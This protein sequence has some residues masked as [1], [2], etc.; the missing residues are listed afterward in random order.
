MAFFPNFL[1]WRYCVIHDAMRTPIPQDH[2]ISCEEALSFFQKDKNAFIY[3]PHLFLNE[4]DQISNENG[5]TSDALYKISTSPEVRK[6]LSWINK[7][8]LYSVGIDY[9]ITV[10]VYVR[11]GS[12][13]LNKLVEDGILTKD[14]SIA[15]HDNLIRNLKDLIST[16][17]E[18]SL[19]F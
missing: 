18:E 16:M 3:E 8:V 19:P 2:T 1:K 12:S 10:D 17:N 5:I 13:M 4:Y 6:V 15:Y 7:H 11:I 9:Y 14:L